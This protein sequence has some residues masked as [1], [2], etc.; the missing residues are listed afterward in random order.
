MA[1]QQQQ[2]QQQHAP[3]FEDPQKKANEYMKDKGITGLFQEL[4]ARLVYHR[5]G[6]PNAFLL[7]TLKDLQS[8]PEPFFNRGDLEAM[9]MAYD[10][11]KRGFITKR[12]CRQALQSIAGGAE[13]R[14]DGDEDD[15]GGVVTK[16][17]WL[18]VASAAAG[19]RPAVL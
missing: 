10:S 9:F 7:Q 1:Q 13:E 5:P 2:Q 8:N 3:A 14:N 17:E 11:G 16:D 19:I 6:D 12:Q 4:G 18:S 15:A